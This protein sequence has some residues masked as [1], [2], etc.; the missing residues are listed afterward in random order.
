MT[1]ARLQLDGLPPLEGTV[2]LGGDY[3][4]F[5]T[6]ER[7]ADLKD[8]SSHRG[9]IEID[10]KSEKAALES[11]SEDTEDATKVVLTLRRFTPS[12]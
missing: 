12:A 1:N 8:G 10:G 7:L 5:K 3:I 6:G 4:R 11:V 2:E 9:Q